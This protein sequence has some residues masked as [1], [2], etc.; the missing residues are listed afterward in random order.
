MKEYE[1]IYQKDNIEYHGII[2]LMLE[3]E[4]HIDIID[5]KLKSID[6]ENYLNQLHG[7]QEY[8]ENLTDKQTDIYLYSILDNTMK[9]LN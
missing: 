1:F 4:E 3:Y 6:D 5:Y 9:K 7:Y 2:D 8:I